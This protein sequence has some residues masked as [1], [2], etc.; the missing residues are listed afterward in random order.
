M[1]DVLK[2]IDTNF[3]FLSNTLEKTLKPFTVLLGFIGVPVR[4]PPGV[5]SH[6]KLLWSC[7]AFFLNLSIQ[8][9]ALVLNIKLNFTKF[10]DQ[11]TFSLAVN[12][13]IDLLNFSIYVILS[14]IILLKISQSNNWKKLSNTFEAL[15]KNLPPTRYFYQQSRKVVIFFMI[16]V[17]FSVSYFLI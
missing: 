10:Q 3:C 13:L 17:L 9:G 14:H 15:E 12:S 6:L 1:C 8:L 5:A 2:Q 16:Y 7:T 4:S 11:T